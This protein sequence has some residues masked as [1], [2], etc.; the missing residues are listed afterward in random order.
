MQRF[1]LPLLF[2]MCFCSFSIMAQHRA[3]NI[4][5]QDDLEISDEKEEKESRFHKAFYVEGL[6]NDVFLSLNYDMRL[7]R[8]RSDGPGIRVGIGGARFTALD[9]DSFVDVGATSVPLEFNYLVGK[10]RHAFE[11]G[12]GVNPFLVNLNGFTVEDDDSLYFMNDVMGF[13]MNVFG[14]IGY[15]FK[16]IRKGLVF[17]ANWTPILSGNGFDNGWIS[18][19]IGYG[20]K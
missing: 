3:E 2:L 20:F 9:F 5:F 17:R 4:T 12:V 7:Q 10:R 15:R 11:T 6:R 1:K 13:G 16:P 14:K 18:I 19:A 8:G